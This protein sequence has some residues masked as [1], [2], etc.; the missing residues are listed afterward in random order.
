MTTMVPR[1]PGGRLLRITPHLIEAAA[2]A[3]LGLLAF[4]TLSSAY[5]R[6]LLANALVNVLLALGLSLTL[7]T[8]RV[9][10]AQATLAG[11]GA[12]VSAWLSVNTSM[13]LLVTV[14]IGTLAAGLV[15][16]FIG[17]LSLRLAGFYF[18]VA[19]LAFSE[20]FT[21]VVGAWQ[22]VTGGLNGIVGVLRFDPVPGFDFSF[23]G[24]YSGYVLLLL[25]VVVGA[26]L[27]VAAMTGRNRIGRRI[28]AVGDDDLIATSL[29]VNPSLW[30][31][32][33]FGTGA[34]IAGLGGSIQ[35]SYLGVAAPSTYNLTASVLVLAMVFLGGKRS[36]PGAVLGAVA[37]TY[38]PEWA[39]F[40]PQSQLLITGV[41]FIAIAFF[42]PDGLIPT[43][44]RLAR[45]IRR[46]FSGATHR[47]GSEV[48]RG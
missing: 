42:L 30:R 8:G 41:F 16:V 6:L 4:S 28:T 12:Y 44:G 9:S 32:I 29:G 10:L 20:V 14:V 37:L 33:A 17:V 7:R 47:Q 21:V 48:G 31:T 22:D 46:V 5:N 1:R 19:T 24:G 23:A 43:I 18:V 2:F 26:Y 25:L 36:L 34:L 40:G 39:R 13:N 38:I 3:T 11:V 15:G 35:V 45:Y 27:L